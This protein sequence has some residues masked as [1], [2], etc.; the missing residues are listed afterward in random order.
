M[1]FRDLKTQYQKLKPE[2]D[3]AVIK[4]MTDSNFISE[5]LLAIENKFADKPNV[6]HW[7]VWFQRLTIKTDRNRDK[8]SSEKLCQIAANNPTAKLWNISWLKPEYQV[9]FDTYQIFNEDIYCQISEIPNKNEVDEEVAVI[10]QGVLETNNKEGLININKATESELDTLP[11]IGPSRAADIISY[12]E[13]NGGF[14][15]IDEIKN[16]KGIGEAS[17]EKLKEKITI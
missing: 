16:V 2:I 4:V 5:M 10:S 12:R 7:R 3:Q 13:S 17:F 15:S 8:D 1:Q 11:G 6:G 14:K 9:V